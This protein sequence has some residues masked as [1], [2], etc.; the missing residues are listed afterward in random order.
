MKNRLVNITLTYGLDLAFV[1]LVAIFAVFFNLRG[2]GGTYLVIF[3]AILFISLLPL[4]NYFHGVIESKISPSSYDDLFAKTVSS[5]MNIT[6][7]NEFLKKTFD[8]TLDLFKAGSGLLVF[9]YPESDEYN[10]FYTRGNRR[11][12]IRNARVE[13]DNPIFSAL[14]GAD[15]IL[16]RSKL[17]PEDPKDLKIIA[18]M[19]KYRGEIVVQ[20]FFQEIFLGL[21]MVGGRKKRFTAGETGLLKLFAS[22]IATLSINSFFFHELLRKKELEK[23]FELAR[24]IHYRF[25]PDA[26]VNLG[27]IAIRV[28]HKTNSLMSREFFDIYHGG[29]ELRLSA[30]HLA[31]D[32]TG[33]S[34]Y[35]PGIQALLQCY[36]K[37]GYSPSSTIRKLNDLF[38]EKDLLD[39]E[40]A[41]LNA[42]LES[43]GRFTFSNSGYQQPFLFRKKTG[44]LE[45]LKQGAKRGLTSLILS[46]G[47]VI[48]V[49][50][51]TYAAW[52]TDQRDAV[53]ELLREGADM[54]AGKLAKSLAKA[55]AARP[56]ADDAD[57]LLIIIRMGE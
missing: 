41:I 50:C 20:I 51:A 1:I 42:S 46:P 6:E 40:I 25:L 54:T 44:R 29:R 10:I 13:K 15:S 43:S 47:D 17:D 33:T 26:E 48:A 32:I 39:D 23:E 19:E 24:K 16:V 56:G 7:F 8:R 2:A 49:C 4:V 9:Y 30:Y 22:K 37:L 34:I 27:P 57:T 45:H 18:E 52:I 38:R 28:Q 31:S 36:A 3:F 35:M 53:R 14:S 11:K 12:L 55:M 21:I 5:I